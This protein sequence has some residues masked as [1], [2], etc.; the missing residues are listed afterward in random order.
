MA[1]RGSRKR[2][3]QPAR[4]GGRRKLFVIVGLI[5]SLASGSIIIAQR[6]S[7]WGAIKP[8][9][10]SPQPVPQQP[11]LAKE[12][13]FAGGRL[14]AT[15]EPVT[16]TLDP[17]TNLVATAISTTQVGLTWTAPPGQVDHYEVQRTQRIDLPFVTLAPPYPTST[18][19]TDITATSGITYLYR[20]RAVG[21]GGITSGYSDV[22]LATTVIFDEDPL[23]A[24][25]TTIKAQHITQLR[26]AVNAVRA[27]ANLQPATWTDSSPQGVFV[28]A[29]H[30]NELRTNLNGGLSTLGFS[31]PS[32]TDPT[33]VPGTTLVKKNHIEELRQAVK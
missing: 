1:K 28:K 22:D 5:L 13:I 9:N 20:V 19:F 23:I 32:Y 14:V 33:L 11:Q 21:P 6:T 29:V 17:P 10:A 31:T 15:E 16:A 18:N 8:G 26:Q 30:I 25:V 24:G 7:L 3:K 27:T 12:Y 4:T 2:S